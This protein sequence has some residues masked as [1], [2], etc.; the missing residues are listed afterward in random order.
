M[1]CDI[2]SRV[3]EL[4]PELEPEKKELPPER[5]EEKRRNLELN[6]E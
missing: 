4:L 3:T 1:L 5:K 2:Q 6:R